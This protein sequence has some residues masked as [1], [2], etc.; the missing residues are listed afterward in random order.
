MDNG[1]LEQFNYSRSLITNWGTAER[2][3]GRIAKNNYAPLG[4]ETYTFCVYQAVYYSVV[5]QEKPLCQP[6]TMT[7]AM[8][9]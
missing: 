7:I 2:G 3:T 1:K 6:I 5:V 9:K 4:R 8:A